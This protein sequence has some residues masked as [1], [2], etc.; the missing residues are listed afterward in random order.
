VEER[1]DRRERKKGTGAADGGGEGRVPEKIRQ[2]RER[3]EEKGKI[4][5][6]RTY[7]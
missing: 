5:F 7:T 4:D 3:T 1:V 6:P 2:K